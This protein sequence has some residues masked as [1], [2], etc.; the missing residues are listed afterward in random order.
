[1]KSLTGKDYPDLN[2][3]EYTYLQIPSTDI[4]LILEELALITLKGNEKVIEAIDNI[5]VIEMPFDMKSIL[6]ESGD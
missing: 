4:E 3:S 2:Q 5:E 6:N 1:M